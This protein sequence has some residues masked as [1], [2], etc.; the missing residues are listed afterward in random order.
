MIRTQEEEIARETLLIDVKKYPKSWS[1]LAS[2]IVRSYHN[3]KQKN[4]STYFDP[5]W[6]D[7]MQSLATRFTGVLIECDSQSVD[8]VRQFYLYHTFKETCAKFGLSKNALK[9]YLKKNK[10]KKTRV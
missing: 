2:A 9:Y 10:I 5:E 7:C 1:H 4:A 8:E 6:L 3:D